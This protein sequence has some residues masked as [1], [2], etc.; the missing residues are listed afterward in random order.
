MPVEQNRSWW[1]RHKKTIRLFLVPCCCLFL[2]ICAYIFK[3]PGT[4]FLAYQDPNTQGY[5]PT[6]NVWDWLQLLALP[7][8]VSIV[9]YWLNSSE[10]ERERRTTAQRDRTDR[11]I[12]LEN[13][14]ATLLQ[15]YL[16]RMSN[17]LLEHKLRNPETDVEARNIARA[18]TLVVLPHLNDERKGRLIQFL[19]ESQ[20][21]L[22]HR[23]DCIPLQN[24]DLREADLKDLDLSGA[25][26]SGANLAGANLTGVN[27]SEAQLRGIVL[28]KADL[29]GATLRSADL[30][31]ASLC[32][33][34]L[35]SAVLQDTN[36]SHANL[37]DA[38]LTLTDFTGADVSDAITTRAR[39]EQVINEGTFSNEQLSKM[40]KIVKK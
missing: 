5:H 7:V 33:A 18:H 29:S 6:K 35:N 17:L 3:M 34:I 40:R 20:L 21:I 25:N 10:S 28:D 37:S 14:R 32:E 39:L 23:K 12:A 26:L 22:S 4:G 36:L 19:Y 2:I 1:S 15:D 13:R 11:A 9:A 16:D 27:L 30:R 31:E 8:F 38:S 24:A